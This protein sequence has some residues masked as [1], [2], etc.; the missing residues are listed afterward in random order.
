MHVP[1]MHKGRVSSP[2]TSVYAQR[3]YDTSG[4]DHSPGAEHL[5][6]VAAAAVFAFAG[7]FGGRAAAVFAFSGRTGSARTQWSCVVPMP[8]DAE[9][10]TAR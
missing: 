5:I 10:R 1:G 7:E 6:E 3:N 4:S 8:G 2:K 9:A